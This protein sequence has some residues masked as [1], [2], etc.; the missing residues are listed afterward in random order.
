MVPVIVGPFPVTEPQAEDS[1]A[2]ECTF[3]EKPQEKIIEIKTPETEASPE[4][5][6]INLRELEQEEMKKETRKI[7]DE[8]KKIAKTKKVYREKYSARSEKILKSWY[9]ENFYDP[10]PMT[11][12]K[13]QL[14]K[15]CGISVNQVNSWFKNVR[16]IQA[17]IPCKFA[18]D[19]EKA[20]LN[21]H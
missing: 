21:A 10:Y 7:K 3:D 6:E 16:Q 20:L 12:E 8:S 13:I 4:A 15:E 14:A 18:N 17:E 19:I 11:E 5:L 1:S 9:M 2:I